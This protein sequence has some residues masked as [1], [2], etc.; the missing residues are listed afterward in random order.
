MQSANRPMKTDDAREVPGKTIPRIGWG[1][2]VDGVT[3]RNFRRYFG[4]GADR[5]SR[6]DSKR[7]NATVSRSKLK[8]TKR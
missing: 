2:Q 6:E 8:P 3:K 4:G 1:E 5:G 7:E